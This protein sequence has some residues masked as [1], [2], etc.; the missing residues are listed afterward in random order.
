MF[1]NNKG[2]KKVRKILS[3]LLA[4][5]MVISLTA[6]GQKPEKAVDE[7]LKNC[8]KGKLPSYYQTYDQDE[9]SEELIKLILSKMT[10]KIEDTN[11]IS[12]NEAQVTVKITSIDMRTAM[13]DIISEYMN[14]SMNQ[15]LSGNYYAQEQ[16]DNKLMELF[17]NAIENNK[18]K[19][20]T[21]TINVKVIKNS[22]GKWEVNVEDT[23]VDALTG[24]LYS[25]MQDI[26]NY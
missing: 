2:G 16:N 20:V 4:V 1:K 5:T 15:I 8:Q 26:A 21:F 6:C 11:Q 10:Y 3:L 23:L 25:S 24:G 13:I 9:Q 12:D 14:W 17:N 18:D 22:S 19:T 7:F